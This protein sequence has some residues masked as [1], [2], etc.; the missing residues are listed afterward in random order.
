MSDIEINLTG[1]PFNAEQVRRLVAEIKEQREDGEPLK[2]KRDY[3]YLYVVLFATAMLA[4]T[5]IIALLQ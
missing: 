1:E 5:C 3:S 2:F 4:L